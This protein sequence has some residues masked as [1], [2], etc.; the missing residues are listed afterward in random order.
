MLLR[1]QHLDFM[2]QLTCCDHGF[3]CGFG[4]AV[5]FRDFIAH[6]VYPKVALLLRP[7]GQQE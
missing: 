2:Q 1:T 3:K 4:F 5:R 7:R 6:I